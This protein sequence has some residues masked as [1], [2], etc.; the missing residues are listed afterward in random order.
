MDKG[1]PEA[2]NDVHEAS[3]SSRAIVLSFV[4]GLDGGFSQTIT[5]H[6]RRTGDDD[7]QYSQYETHFVD[8]EQDRV[9]ELRLSGS[10]FQSGRSYDIF[11]Q[12]DNSH[13]EGEASQSPTIT[14]SMPGNV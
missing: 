12:A 10:G 4:P 3:V 13:T 7:A 6:Y 8:P 1:K 9:Y 14:V 2:P 5:A 11:L